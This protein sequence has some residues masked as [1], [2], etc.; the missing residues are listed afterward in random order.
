[1]GRNMRKKGVTRMTLKRVTVHSEIQIKHRLPKGV[2]AEVAI[3]CLKD[4]R[5]D[6]PICHYMMDELCSQTDLEAIACAACARMETRC[7]DDLQC[8]SIS[9]SSSDHTAI[10]EQFMSIAWSP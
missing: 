2:C 10:T 9:C 1:M 4:T 8:S 5:E 6:L 7:D 3:H